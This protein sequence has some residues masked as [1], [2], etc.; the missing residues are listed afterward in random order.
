MIRTGHLNHGGINNCDV[1]LF[2]HLR[3]GGRVR[4]SE[5]GNGTW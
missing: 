3:E 4:Q 1:N 5:W 2:V